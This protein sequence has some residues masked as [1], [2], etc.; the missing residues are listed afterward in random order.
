MDVY[1]AVRS[2][3]AVRAYRA[4][5]VPE[6]VLVR[7]LDAGRLTGSGMNAQPWHFVAV[8]EPSTIAQLAKAAPSGPYLAGAPAAIVVAI[9]DGKSTMQIS[10][11]SRAM[12]SMILTAWDAGIGSNWV[13]F[14][15][16]EAVNA[17][18]VLPADKHVLGIIAL[19]YPAQPAGRGKK[20]R[21]PLAE[22]ASRERYGQ[23]FT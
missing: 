22:V 7:I 23:P 5:P 15:R 21:K 2:V 9:D 4:D 18:V 1:D 3:L 12:H 16:L 17:I 14:G 20:N 13:G 8:Q 6:D 19:G 11:A 10:D